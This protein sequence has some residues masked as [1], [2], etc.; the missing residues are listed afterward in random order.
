MI[1]KK[2]NWELSGCYSYLNIAPK[3]AQIYGKI[4][5]VLHSIKRPAMALGALSIPGNDISIY[6]EEFDVLII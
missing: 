4:Y 1:V 2:Q 6:F 3:S 5:A